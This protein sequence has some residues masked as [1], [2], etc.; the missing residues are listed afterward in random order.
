MDELFGLA[1]GIAEGKKDLTIIFDKGMNSEENIDFIDSHDQIHFITTYSTYFADYLARRDPHSFSLLEIRKNNTLREEDRL[2]AYRTELVLWGGKRS[3]V[4]TFNPL[5]YRKKLYDFTRKM[6]RIRC[7]LLE[8]RRKYN[9]KEPQWRSSKK[10]LSRYRKLCESLYISPEY[11]QLNFKGGTMGFRKDPRQVRDAEAM[12][13]KNIIVTDK[14]H[15]STEE[16]V[17]A[18]LDRASIERQFQV[19]KSQLRVNPMFHWTDSKIRCHLLCCVFAL[20]ALRLLELQIGDGLSARRAVEEMDQLHSVLTWQ[21]HSDSPQMSIEEPDDIQ[22]HI[23]A[24]FG[25]QVKDSWVLQ[26]PS[27]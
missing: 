8:F 11:W 27:Q 1:M 15:W 3:V 12:M 21:V 23:L 10:V 9:H 22:S 17:Q 4:V 24:S 6:D 19:S 14:H 5:T 18:S 13:G 20:T 2:R 25:Y 16:I 26:L 7:A